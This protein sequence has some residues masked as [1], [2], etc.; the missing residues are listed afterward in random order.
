MS[1]SET[2]QKLAFYHGSFV[3]FE[4][5]KRVQDEPIKSPPTLRLHKKLQFGRG[6]GAG[7][8]EIALNSWI[9]LLVEELDKDFEETF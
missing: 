7:F 3:R 2:L 8:S 4:N 6:W 9:E 5:L 1:S